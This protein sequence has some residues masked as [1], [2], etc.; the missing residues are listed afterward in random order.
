MQQIN[1]WAVLTYFTVWLVLALL[2]QEPFYLLCLLVGIVFLHYRA[3]RG[4]RLKK[5]GLWSV[6]LVVLLVLLNVL[7]NRSGEVVLMNIPWPG[8]PLPIFLEPLIFSLAMAIKLILLL[9]IFALLQKYFDTDRLVALAGG[10]FSK[11]I[12]IFALALRMFPTMIQDGQR[13]LGVLRS[14]GLMIEKGNRTQRIK[15]LM[16]LGQ[17]M[18]VSALEGAMHWAEAMRVRGYGTGIRTR[19]YP[20]IMAFEDIMIIAISLTILG[21]AIAAYLGGMG[22]NNPYLI[23]GGFSLAPALIPALIAGGLVLTALLA[24]GEQ[25]ETI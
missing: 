17:I 5:I 12:L 11:S 16:P 20:E 9:L 3:D 2:Y 10:R 24:G 25:A 1:S 6:P 18:L 4:M 7:V 23:P 8:A 21:G 14:R 15:S 19:F 13:I 22:G